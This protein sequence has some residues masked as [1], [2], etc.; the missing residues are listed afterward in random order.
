MLKSI[1]RLT[2]YT[3]FNAALLTR[4]RDKYH[5]SRFLTPFDWHLECQIA[6]K[7]YGIV[8]KESKLLM[9]RGSD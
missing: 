8:P 5:P 2:I 3:G 6:S 7:F 9:I 1:I 4:T